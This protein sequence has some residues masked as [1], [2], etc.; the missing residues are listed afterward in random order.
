VG[1][2]TPDLYRVKRPRGLPKYAEVIQDVLFVGWVVAWKSE[3]GMSGYSVESTVSHPGHTVE[4]RSHE[5]YRTPERA[6]TIQLHDA[7]QGVIGR[8]NAVHGDGIPIRVPT[9]GVH[10]PKTYCGADLLD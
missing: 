1:T 8:S 10:S 6:G 3:N 9:V 2:R 5:K 4:C 7:I